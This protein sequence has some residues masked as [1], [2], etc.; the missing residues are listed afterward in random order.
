MRIKMP[1]GVQPKLPPLEP[2]KFPSRTEQ[3]RAAGCLVK[4]YDFDGKED[5]RGATY[6]IV[7]RPDA[8]NTCSTCG[9]TKKPK[10]GK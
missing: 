2:G 10:K 3:L 7:A 9:A 8:D 4:R 5:P 6:D 1:P